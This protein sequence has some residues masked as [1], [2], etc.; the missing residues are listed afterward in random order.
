LTFAQFLA[1][2]H[3]HDLRDKGCQVYLK[4]DYGLMDSVWGKVRFTNEGFYTNRHDLDKAWQ[5]FKEAC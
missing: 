2:L 5:A 4:A 1:S 3:F